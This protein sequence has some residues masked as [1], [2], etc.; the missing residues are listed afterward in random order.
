M[1]TEV[2]VIILGWLLGFVI[3]RAWKKLKWH[4]VEYGQ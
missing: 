3:D 2:I 1:G 4:G